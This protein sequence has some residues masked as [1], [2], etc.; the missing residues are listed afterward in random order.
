MSQEPIRVLQIVG[1]MDRGGIETMIMNL[2][3]NID[4][5]KV[6]FDFLAHY[7]REAAYNDEIRAL[8]GRIYEMPPLKDEKH[9][10]YWRLFSYIKALNRFFKA[11]P[12]YRVIHGHMTN[13]A[14]IYMPIAKKHGVTCRISHSHNT[15]GK[16]GLLGMATNFL[17]KPI[18]KYATDYFACS[19][20][21]KQ[22]FYPEKLIAS[23]NVRVLANAVDAEGYRFDPKKR[24]KIRKELNLAGKL[25]VVCVARFRPEKNQTF[26]LDV[27]QEMCRQREN[28]V[29][30]FAGDGPCEEPVKARA[31]E[32]HLEENTR[33]LG[34]RE[35]IPDVLSASDV[36]VLPSFW[37]GLPVTVIEAQANGL[38]CVVTHGLTEEMN[39]LGMVAYV[40][41]EDGAAAWANAL[42]QGADCPREDTYGR[43]KASGYDI[44]TT[45]PWLQNFYSKKYH[46]SQRRNVYEN[47]NTDPLSGG[48]PWGTAPALRADRSAEANGA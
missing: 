38:H 8:G 14:S 25:V 30:V 35:D 10:Y 37:E 4:R 31:K 44:H 27:L 19:E 39:A 41:L 26:L 45:A 40:P 24:E 47:R 48:K 34:M 32:M 18:Y 9:V 29:F 17:Q 5:E 42:F 46:E 15:H 22:W 23:G 13:T 16:S 28:V 1:R 6:Q 3:R 2:Y 36:F 33:F 7:G 11:H 43:M 20:A 12:E 21:A